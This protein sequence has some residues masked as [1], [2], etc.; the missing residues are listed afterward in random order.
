MMLTFASTSERL[1]KYTAFL[2]DLNTSSSNA[3]DD[4]ENENYT[5]DIIMFRSTVY[6]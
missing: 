4:K 1:S 6:T 2:Y 3:T 5:D